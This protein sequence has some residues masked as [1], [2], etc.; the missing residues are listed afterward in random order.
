MRHVTFFHKETGLLHHVSVLV[1]DD[2]A[3]ALNTPHDHIAID[4][5]PEGILDRLSQ[6]VDVTTGE[7]VAYQPPRPSNNHEWDERSKRWKPS[8]ASRARVAALAQI[9]M[10]EA[11][12][13]RA[14]REFLLGR[15]SADRL[16]EI[17]DQIGE[18]RKLL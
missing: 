6:R 12:Q 3:V 5:P 17:D 10:L 16:R 14:I 4:H 1:S 2:A 13:S 9:R 15:G 11:N 7:V 18:L 8:E